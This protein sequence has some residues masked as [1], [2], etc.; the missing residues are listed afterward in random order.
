MYIYNNASVLN[1]I[2]YNQ[3]YWMLVEHNNIKK[4]S[5]TYI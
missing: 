1:N 3:S 5:S 4:K 2:A